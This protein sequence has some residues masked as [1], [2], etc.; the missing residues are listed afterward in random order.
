MPGRI[1]VR[2][3]VASVSRHAQFDDFNRR[4]LQRH[5]GFRDRR[6]CSDAT[7]RPATRSMSSTRTCSWSRYSG[8][9]VRRVVRRQ[10]G[11]RH[12]DVA[13][14]ISGRVTHQISADEHVI[15]RELMIDPRTRLVVVGGERRRTRQRTERNPCSLTIDGK[16]R[17]HRPL[18]APAG[19]CF[20]SACT[21][22]G[23]RRPTAGSGVP[24]R[25]AHHST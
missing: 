5:P 1:A 11:R 25:S 13:A 7:T 21:W 14:R 19:R 16:R 23:R 4:N 17:R 6:D 3:L 2:V 12:L 10:P 24:P 18:A 9:S 8:M 22:G 20:S 15:R